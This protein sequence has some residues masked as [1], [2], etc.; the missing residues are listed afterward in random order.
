M[1]LGLRQ[2]NLRTK[3]LLTMLSLLVLSVTS[4]FFLHLYSERRLISQLHEYTEDLSTAIEVFQEQ[5]VG[6]GDAQVVLK[7][8]MEKLGKLGSRTFTPQRRGRRRQPATSAGG[9][10]DEA[11]ADRRSS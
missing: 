1:T 2:L 10:G 5:P 4:L 3:L 9:W 7:A 6:E 11:A 8:Y